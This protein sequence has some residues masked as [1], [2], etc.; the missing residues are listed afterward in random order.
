MV[1]GMEPRLGRIRSGHIPLAAVSGGYVCLCA[2]YRIV[3]VRINGG[4]FASDC[5]TR[6]CA[7]LFCKIFYDNSYVLCLCFRVKHDSVSTSASD[8][9]NEF[10]EL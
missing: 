9:F 4:H 6:T 5:R 2:L 3:L 10:I 8:F 7:R 1:R